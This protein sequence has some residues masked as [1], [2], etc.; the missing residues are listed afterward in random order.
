MKR[1]KDRPWQ[2]EVLVER[3]AARRQ[4]RSILGGLGGK[5]PTTAT[6]G[7]RATYPKQKWRNRG[8]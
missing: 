4:L 6:P 5:S 7:E 3:P 2:G 1:P 8:A